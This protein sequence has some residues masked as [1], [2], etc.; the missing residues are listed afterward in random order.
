MWLFSLG[1]PAIDR[2]LRERLTWRDWRPTLI[3]SGLT[4]GAVA[5]LLI[6]MAGVS[7]YERPVALASLT[8]SVYW[9][10]AAVIGAC[11]TIAALTLTTISLL[12]RL[13]TRKMRPLALFHLRLTELA[14]VAAIAFAMGALLLTTFPVTGPAD[15]APPRWQI[16]AV[17]F[18]LL[19][20]TALTVGAFAVVLTSLAATA[21]EIFRTLPEEVVKEILADAPA[22]A[23]P[24]I[25][26]DAAGDSRPE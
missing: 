24:G 17:F 16:D 14:A 8:S 23:E 5:L 4:A 2:A 26:H 15:I 19:L 1:P 10:A 3:A 12:D 22:P 11:G 18:G 13:E 25:S 9:I 21:A 6:A 7:P 20:L